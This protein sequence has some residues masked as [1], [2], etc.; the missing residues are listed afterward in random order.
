MI[1]AASVLVFVIGFGVYV[2]LQIQKQDRRVLRVTDVDGVTTEIH[3]PLVSR[4]ISGPC[5]INACPYEDVDGLRIQDSPGA[6]PEDILW[7]QL[8]SVVFAPPEDNGNEAH[9]DPVALLT[10]RDGTTRKAS[11]TS[12]ELEGVVEL[13]DYTVSIGDLKTII[14]AE[15]GEPPLPQDPGSS[16]DKFQITEVNGTTLR[17]EGSPDTA[18]PTIVEGTSYHNFSD[19]AQDG[20]RLWRGKAT[21]EIKWRNIK[22]V[23]VNADKGPDGQPILLVTCVFANGQSSAFTVDPAPG[24]SIRQQVP[25]SEQF[26]EVKLEDIRRIVVN[27]RP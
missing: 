6:A 2:W 23:S 19:D 10:L 22:E 5:S 24:P 4:Y 20:I 11:V 12:Y 9:P 27:P 3:E 16:E 14:V 26:N 17:W 13:A 25:G 18:Y 8:A 1:G 15:G 7:S 21:F